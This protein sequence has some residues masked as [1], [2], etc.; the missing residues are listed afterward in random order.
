MQSTDILTSTKRHPSIFRLAAL[1]VAGCIRLAA[2][3]SLHLSGEYLNRTFRVHNADYRVFRDT[4]APLETAERTVLVVGFRLKVI[5]SS[6][7]W[8]WLFQRLC[9][10]TT[11]FWSGFDGFREK[12]WM[13][14]EASKDY[15]GIYQWGEAQQAQTYVEALVRVLRPLSVRGSVWYEIK[16]N[17][18]LNKFLEDRDRKPGSGRV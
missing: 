12:L 11:P 15:L 17:V 2:R 3:G 5:R 7:V 9:I 16:N 1:S 4:V 8:H 14:D 18:E 10:V 13:V 6:K